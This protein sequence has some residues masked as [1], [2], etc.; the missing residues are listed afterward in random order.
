ML[1]LF[2]HDKENTMLENNYGGNQMIENDQH[3]K[4]VGKI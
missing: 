3:S 4:R 2:Q 1:Q